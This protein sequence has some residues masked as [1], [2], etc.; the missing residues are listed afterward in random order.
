MGIAAR[1]DLKKQK[2][3]G[4]NSDFDIFFIILLSFLYELLHNWYHR[5]AGIFSLN[6]VY[7]MSTYR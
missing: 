4:K 2:Y 5:I 3:Y 6:S 7:S 1:S